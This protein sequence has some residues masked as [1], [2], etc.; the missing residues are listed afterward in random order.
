[1]LNIYAVLDSAVGVYANPVMMN[2]DG[3]AMRSF[4]DAVVN[5]DSPLSN[6]P[7]DYT[8]YL[9]GTWDNEKCEIVG[10]PPKKVING[11][12]A[13]NNR[14]VRLDKQ[15]DLEEEIARLQAEDEA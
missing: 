3:E 6:H 11:L 13:V 1:M 9:I 8:L 15:R 5:A 7:Q 2:T 10:H 4:T 14:K 12:E